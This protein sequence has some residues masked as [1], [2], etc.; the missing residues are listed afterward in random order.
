MFRLEEFKKTQNIRLV[1]VFAL[2]PFMIW[3]GFKAKNIND[4]ARL[5]MILSGVAT[6]VYNGINYIKNKEL[7]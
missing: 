6:I 2:G 4:S 3:F 5:I 1:D 7:E